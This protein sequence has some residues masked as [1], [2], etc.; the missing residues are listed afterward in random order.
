MEILELSMTIDPME[1]KGLAFPNHRLVGGNPVA[2]KDFFFSLRKESM[3]SE[4]RAY[5]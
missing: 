5:L 4:T 2:M 1:R 3:H